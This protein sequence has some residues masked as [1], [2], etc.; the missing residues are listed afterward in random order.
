MFRTL[1]LKLFS[2]FIRLVLGTFFSLLINDSSNF[3][4]AALLQFNTFNLAKNITS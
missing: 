4:T 1:N 2:T 3:Y